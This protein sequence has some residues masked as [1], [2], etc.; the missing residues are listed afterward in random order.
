MLTFSAELLLEKGHKWLPSNYIKELF[1]AQSQISGEHSTTSMLQ[2][3]V[4]EI[5][6]KKSSSL[7]RFS[8]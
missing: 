1:A 5:Q 3:K 6:N 8:V 4:I 2:Q 7:E